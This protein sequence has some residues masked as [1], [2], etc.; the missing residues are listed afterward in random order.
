MGIIG[1]IVIGGLAGWLAGIITGQKGGI[2]RNIIIGIIGAF[3]GGFI[4]SLFD[5]VGVTGF[6]IWS[7]LVALGGAI[8]LIWIGNL[9]FGKKK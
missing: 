4:V 8:V 6:N 9:L 3:V 1:W 7:L 2:L 5:G